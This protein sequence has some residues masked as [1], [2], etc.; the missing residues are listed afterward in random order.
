M[1]KRSKDDRVHLRGGS[2]AKIMR[3]RA[4]KILERRGN[5]IGGFRPHGLL[6]SASLVVEFRM[7][8][9]ARCAL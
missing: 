4:S 2:G 5:T 9:G 7:G 1:K 8:Q 3:R 6:A